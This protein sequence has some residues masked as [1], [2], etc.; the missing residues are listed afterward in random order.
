MFG[1]LF[2]GQRR[3]LGS[4]PDAPH[5]PNKGRDREDQTLG[6]ATEG[7]CDQK[8][9]QDDVHGRHGEVIH[10]RAGCGG[11]LGG[12]NCLSKGYLR[13]LHGTHRFYLFRAQG[14]PI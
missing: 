12:K 7:S 4:A 5:Q 2:R 9:E 8:Q 14:P 3:K 6:E 1:E 13:F 10:I 11:K